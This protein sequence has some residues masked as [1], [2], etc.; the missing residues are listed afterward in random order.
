MYHGCRAPVGR[1]DRQSCPG[2]TTR[3]ASLE[4]KLRPEAPMLGCVSWQAR[5]CASQTRG[6]RR[7]VIPPLDPATGRLPFQG[8]DRPFRAA[9]P[10]VH[11]R[12]VEGHVGEEHR[13]R[14]WA[15]FTLWHELVQ[16]ELPGARY[17][18]SGSYLTDRPRPSDLDVILVLKPGHL[19]AM[20]PEPT[21]EARV[22]LT[23]L[24]VTSS[25][26]SGTAERLQPV[27]GLVDGH[28]CYSWIPEHVQLWQSRWSN[29]Y[30][31]ATRAPTGV[32]MGYVEVNS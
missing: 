25:Q 6:G 7:R 24:G 14:I 8:E 17:W 30:D 11:Q 12:F 28:W 2:G 3:G 20:T 23:H 9:L 4:V 19:K 18:L 27:G 26:P 13:T 10:E 21:P 15:A 31:K 1:T 29:V 5:A 32:R 22:L 16:Q